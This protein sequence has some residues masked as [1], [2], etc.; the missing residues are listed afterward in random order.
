MSFNAVFYTFSKKQNS[1]AR[2]SISGTTLSVELKDNSSV[3]EPVLRLHNTANWNPSQLNYCYIFK[4]TRWYYVE[5]WEYSI[6]EWICYLKCDVLATY[7]T[8]IGTLSKYVLRSSYEYDKD[9]IDAFYPAKELEP[10]QYNDTS[11]F[12]FETDADD[13]TYIIGIANNS[14]TDGVPADD[15]SFGSLQY[16]AL[17]GYVFRMLVKK[18]LP[19]ETGWATVF[20]GLTD[21]LYRSIYNPWD[22]I[23]SCKWFPFDLYADYS[24]CLGDYEYIKFGN[25]ETTITGKP[26]KRDMATWLELSKTVY[27]PTTWLTMD[28]K[29]KAK[30]YAHIY[31][32][33][34]PWGVI[35]LNSKDFTDSR[36]I[37]VKAY[38]DL[39]TGDAIL[40]IY[41]SPG[42]GN[43]DYFIT[44]SNAKLAVDIPLTA[45]TIDARSL[46]GGAGKVISGAI[47]SGIGIQNNSA[48]SIGFGSSMI[49]G[50]VIDA[51]IASVPT[52]STSIGQ[53]T[54]SMRALDG[55][56][57]LIFTST[58]F[59]EELNSEYGKPLY[60]TKVISSIPGYIKCGDSDC[61]AVGDFMFAGEREQVGNHLM[62]GFFY[63]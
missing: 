33:C 10:T 31:I 11:S 56:I 42:T 47:S 9:I 46:L 41:K 13:G 32:V 44:Q 58:D 12:N 18:M 57:L 54:N 63:E 45:A 51:A 53:T 38:P 55:E 6:G 3:V 22:Y 4:F 35:E 5:D 15:T 37:R 28:A 30:P 7:K 25:Y 62:N 16:F 26:I 20:T 43:T 61:S 49:I 40:K 29:Y 24:S 17:S 50:G 52:I 39:V 34:N 27:L 48:K 14:G 36:T 23:K 8:Y 60:K 21:S 1:T 59:V 2:P 19:D